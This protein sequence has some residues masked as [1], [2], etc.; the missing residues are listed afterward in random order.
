MSTQAD[1]LND[2]ISGWID[3]CATLRAAGATLAT[4]MEA[5]A[6]VHPGGCAL[7]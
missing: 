1:A 3:A 6:S 7:L 5:A 2:A 4:A